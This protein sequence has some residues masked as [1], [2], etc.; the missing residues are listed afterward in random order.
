M[1][2]DLTYWLETIVG[3]L[4]GFV[5]LLCQNTVYCLERPVY[6]MTYYVSSGMVGKL[7]LRTHSLTL[8]HI[9]EA[10]LSVN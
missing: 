1:L 4:R 7:Y 8:V 6:K 5:L 10:I 3:V 9:L 2:S